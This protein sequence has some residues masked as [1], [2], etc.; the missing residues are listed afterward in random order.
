MKIWYWIKDRLTYVRIIT[1]GYFLVT[2]LGTGLLLLPIAT[3]PGK[4]TSFGTALFTAASST[5]V[6]GLMVVDPGTHFSIFG[7]SVLL[8]LIQI[9]G[10]GFVSVCVMLS[11]LLKKKI[12]LKTRGLLQESMNG[13]QIGGIVKVVK[14]AL[15]GTV[16]FEI[17]GTLMLAIKFVPMFGMGQGFFYS[18]FHSVS[19]FCNA[20]IEVFGSHFGEYP[21]LTGF[22]GDIPV[23]L[24]MIILTIVGGVGFFVW[25][26]LKQDKFH[27]KKCTLHTKMVLAMSSVLLIVGT[28]LYFLFE[29]KNLFA[30]MTGPEQVITALFCSAMTR[31]TGFSVVDIAEFSNASKLL[32]IVLSFIGGSP[33]STAGGI[34]TVTVFVLVLYIWSN[35]SGKRSVTVF[36][37]RLDDEI[38]Q[39]ASNVLV[40][41]LM[42][43]TGACMLICFMQPQLDVLDVLIE[44]TSAIGTAG[45][46]T[47]ITRDLGV[48]SRAII[49]ILM[50]CGRIGSMSFALS[51]VNKKKEPPLKQPVEKIMIG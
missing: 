46:S 29:R 16:L 38:I 49:I 36:K 34:K 21:S 10:L 5:C 20:G 8:V 32:T 43:A 31:T 4:T 26:D 25:A 23:N 48:G 3:V 1:I 45:M 41:S 19:A 47:G 12:T 11:L 35:L 39:K 37:R 27:I 17:L 33:G 18:I 13:V 28:V 51:V 15:L 22:R 2:L 6:T 42:L 30:D 14:L 24:I 44:V 7:Q 9:G 40:L 50:Y